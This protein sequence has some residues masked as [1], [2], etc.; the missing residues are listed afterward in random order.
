MK[1]L[2]STC[3]LIIIVCLA[4]LIVLPEIAYS[5]VLRGRDWVEENYNFF[6]VNIRNTIKKGGKE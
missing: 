3:E 1:I 5:L 6:K 4:V 2:E